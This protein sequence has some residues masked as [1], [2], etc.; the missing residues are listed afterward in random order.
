M[1]PYE[2]SFGL[3][4]RAIWKGHLKL[5]ELVCPIAL[6]TAVSASERVALHMLNRKTGHRLHRQFVDQDTGKEVAQ[7][8]QV[9][10]YE[11]SRGD[12]IV[13]D[14]DEIEAAVP[15]GDKTL[16]V[17]SFIPAKEIDNL[18]L[19]RPYYLTPSGAGADKA[20]AIFHAGLMKKDVAALAHAVLFR[21]VRTVLIRPYDN[22]L[23]ATTLNFDYELR[24]AKEAFSGIP[25]I[26]IKKEMLDLAK[27]IIATKK[28]SFD[29]SKFEDRYEAA[30][31][32]L[33]KAKIEGREIEPPQEPERTN[34]VD[35]M[36]ALR[37]SAKPGKPVAAKPAKG[38][39]KKKAAAS[40]TPRKTAQKK[41]SPKKTAQRKPAHTKTP[42]KAAQ[43]KA[44]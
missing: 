34:V 23:I 38:A 44:G 39:A 20:Y 4:Q 6:H 1:F 28:G 35:L 11:A 14:Q 40:K 30:L 19:D 43:R 31:A 41:T 26:K 24:P 36:E 16:S 17:D 25:A 3:A 37:R 18:Y 22:G 10:G 2:G 5:G 7:E 29:P 33:V 13:F 27:H 32:D 9:K 21:R 15:A 12:Y 8:D 42:Q